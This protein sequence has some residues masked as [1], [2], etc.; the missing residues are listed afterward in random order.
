VRLDRL[1][2]RQLDAFYRALQ[3]KGLSGSSIHQHHSILHAALGRAVKWGL[4]A[5]NPADRATPR[6]ARSTATA[7]A[8]AEVQKLIAEAEADGDHGLATA[9]A[10]GAV[11]GARGA[12]CAHSG[13]ATWT[14]S[15]ACSPSPVP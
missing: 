8:V 5:A 13:G 2:T 3:Q 4:I 14:L 9:I 7:P 15:A 12:S 6:P 1:T 11:T 10:L